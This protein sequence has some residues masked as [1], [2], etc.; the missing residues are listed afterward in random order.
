MLAA[1]ETS[2]EQLTQALSL[3]Q[4]NLGRATKAVE[5]AKADFTQKQAYV[6]NLK[7]VTKLR[8]KSRQSKPS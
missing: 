1:Q 5:Q 4:A 6:T 7:Q 8:Q 2:L 3:A